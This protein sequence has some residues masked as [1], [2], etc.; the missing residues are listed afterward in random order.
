[1]ASEQQNQHKSKDYS[2]QDAVDIIH[3]M[4]A[5]EARAFLSPTEDRASVHKAVQSLAAS[6]NGETAPAV[7]SNALVNPAQVGTIV[8]GDMDTTRKTIHDLAGSGWDG[9]DDYN[10]G[11]AV[12]ALDLPKGLPTHIEI[13]GR[14]IE[15]YYPRL[16]FQSAS[17]HEL[18]NKMKPVLYDSPDIA[19]KKWLPR[20]AFNGAGELRT[21]DL[22]TFVI[23]RSVWDAWERDRRRPFENT[24]RDIGRGEKPQA[25]PDGG[26]VQKD[27]LSI[28]AHHSV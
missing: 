18:F 20:H 2:A 22:M 24:L 9:F 4:T 28:G 15:V 14:M 21:G 8:I 26:G 19:F 13:Q 25:T 17:M 6:A 11:D 16:H 12:D 1:M 5:E 27:P 3:S 10:E 23:A 7:G